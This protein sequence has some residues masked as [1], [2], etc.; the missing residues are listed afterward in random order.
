MYKCLNTL[1]SDY[2]TNPFKDTSNV[3]PYPTKIAA[4][5]FMDI[6]CPHTE[7]LKRSFTLNG[8]KSLSALP[9]SILSCTSLN[10]S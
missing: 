9:R 10:I 2:L 5:N 7:M 3:Q 4:N 1:A 8:A 6:P